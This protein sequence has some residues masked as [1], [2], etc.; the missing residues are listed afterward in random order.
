MS[1]RLLQNIFAGGN[2][3][4]GSLLLAM[5]GPTLLHARAWP[6]SLEQQVLLLVT[7]S[8]LPLAILAVRFPL[9]AG[10]AQFSSAFIGNQML[11]DAPLPDLRAFSSASMAIA[12]AILF[13]AVFRGILEITQEAY[14]EVED[15]DEKRATGVA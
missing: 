8:V 10:I 6:P 5:Y 15:Q 9:V 7:A 4:F 2:C 14:G 13:V 3:V 1:V 12:L 11:H